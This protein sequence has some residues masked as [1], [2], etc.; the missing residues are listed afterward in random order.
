MK[1]QVTPGSLAAQ[2]L[3]SGDIVIMVQ[4]QD[5]RDMCHFDAYDLMKQATSTLEIT[6]RKNNSK[7]VVKILSIYFL[8]DIFIIDLVKLKLT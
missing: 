6:V 2:N 7:Y 5:A 8:I 4:G 1:F 3:T